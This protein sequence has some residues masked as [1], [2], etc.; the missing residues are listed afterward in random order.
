[1]QRA[2]P[3]T[4]SRR[5]RLGLSASLF[6]MSLLNT[7]VIPTSAREVRTHARCVR[8]AAIRVAICDIMAVALAAGV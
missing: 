5:A 4:V 3:R 2:L 6:R 7:M 8:C 1:M